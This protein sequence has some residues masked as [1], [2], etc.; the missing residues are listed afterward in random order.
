MKPTPLTL[1][2][3]AAIAAAAFFACENESP[4]DDDNDDNGD[5][6]GGDDSGPCDDDTAWQ[7]ECEDNHAPELFGIGYEVNGEV[8]S[9]PAVVTPADQVVLLLD[10]RDLDCNISEYKIDSSSGTGGVDSFYPPMGCSSEEEGGLYRFQVEF[11]YFGAFGAGPFYMML[12]DYC[13]AGSEPWTQ[14]LIEWRE[15]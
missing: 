7:K 5:D 1:A 12:I 8:V 2:I 6:A 4:D 13:G 3:V 9:P 11:D 15:P 14:V 10:Y